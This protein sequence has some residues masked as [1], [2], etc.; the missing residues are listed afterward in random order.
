MK[1]VNGCST[2]LAGEEKYEFFYDYRNRGFVQYDYRDADDGELFSC[3]AKSLALAR[4]K[5][6]LWKKNKKK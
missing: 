6:D 4:A 3:V 1:D 5:R 2:C